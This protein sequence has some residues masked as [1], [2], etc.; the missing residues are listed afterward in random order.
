MALKATED[1]HCGSDGYR[2]RMEHEPASAGWQTRS[3][4]GTC[5]HLRPT[6][7][8]DQQMCLSLKG[9]YDMTLSMCIPI[10]LLLTVAGGVLLAIS[11]RRRLGAALVILGMLLVAA[12][13]AIIGLAISSM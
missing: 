11:R 9:T 13:C 10:G 7:D 5:H 2:G 4:H 1:A 8:N 3:T 12:T 6:E